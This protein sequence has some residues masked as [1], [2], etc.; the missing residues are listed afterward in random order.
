[1]SD[2]SFLDWP[3]LNDS[4][5]ALA[6]EVDAWAEEHLAQLTQR[7]EEDLDGT[8]KAIVKGLGDAGFLRHAVPES[9]GGVNPKLDV[10]S[11]SIIRETLARYH[12]LADF[13]FAMQGL[14]SGP[15]SLFGSEQQ[16]RR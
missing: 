1:M 3:F 12:A 2:Q 7:E 14:G 8:C 16:R 9:G 13:A 5:R 15:I 6:A 10:R 4:H 11:L